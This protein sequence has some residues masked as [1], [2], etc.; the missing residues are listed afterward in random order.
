MPKKPQVAKS[1]SE[2]TIYTELSAA[3]SCTPNEGENKTDFYIRLCDAVNQIEDSAFDA[4]SEA[5]RKWFNAAGV[6]INN[7]KPEAIPELD[8]VLIL[9]KTP[10][11]PIPAPSSKKAKKETPVAT[12]KTAPKTAE[13]AP[14]KSAPKIA[15]KSDG[16]GRRGR[17]PGHGDADT[18]KMLV[19]DNPKREGSAAYKRFEL[20]R[21]HA[22]VA[23]FLKAGGTR[24]DLRYDSEHKHIT[25]SG[26]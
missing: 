18:I 24:S 15:A 6:A 19:K 5:S 7:K 2:N 9:E 21:K 22:T 12:A 13:K 23:T 14:A 25:I 8:G 10:P 4:L 1:G 11:D 16:S 26:K 20:Y 3:G 17:A